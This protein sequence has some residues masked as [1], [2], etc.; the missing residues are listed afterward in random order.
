MLEKNK[1]KKGIEFK[2]NFINLME[3][4]FINVYMFL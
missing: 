1:K 2:M 3:K 4:W